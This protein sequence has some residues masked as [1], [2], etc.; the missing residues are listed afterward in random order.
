MISTAPDPNLKPSEAVDL[1]VNGGLA[2][3]NRGY[4]HIPVATP[5]VL[6]KPSGNATGNMSSKNEWTGSRCYPFRASPRF[7]WN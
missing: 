4:L 2:P 3:L 1:R 7:L 6:R 5:C